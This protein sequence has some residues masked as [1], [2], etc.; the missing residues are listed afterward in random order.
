MSQDSVPAIVIG[1]LP[2]YLRMLAYLEMEGK[3]VTSSQELADRLGLS[4]AQIRKD[5]SYF[6]EFG[7]QGTGYHIGYLQKQLRQILKIDR[8]WD[9]IIVGA[10]NLGRALGHY[11]GFESHGFRLAGLFDNSE[12]KI[13]TMV[14]NIKIQDVAEMP[15]VVREKRVQIAVLAVPPEVAQ[16]VA[17][18]L[19]ELGVRAILN[20]APITL[21]TP[22]RAK[23]YYL[24]PVVGLQTMTYYLA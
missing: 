16:S 14:G 19:V 13:G 15:Q 21:S 23:V 1:R 6:G 17:D 3:S 5:L 9:M 11:E 7:K 12:K 22:P 4:S 24:D 18:Q 10:G 2:I 8:V 20:Y